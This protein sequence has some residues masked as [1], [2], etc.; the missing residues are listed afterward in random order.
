MILETKIQMVVLGVGLVVFGFVSPLLNIIYL[1]KFIKLDAARWKIR[2]VLIIMYFLL[3]VLIYWS[4]F[5]IYN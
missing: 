3:F 5:I 2:I 4:L 1:P